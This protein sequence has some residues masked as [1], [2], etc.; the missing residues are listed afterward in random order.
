MSK[1]KDLIDKLESK[2]IMP[3]DVKDKK[4]IAWIDEFGEIFLKVLKLKQDLG[5]VYKKYGGIR[6]VS[7]DT[8]EVK[9]IANKIGSL[10]KREDELRKKI[11]KAG[12]YLPS[13]V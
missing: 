12:V 7:R 8:P 9:E 4:V 11:K 5:K 3:A 13:D 6:N 10:Y 2:Q 1:A